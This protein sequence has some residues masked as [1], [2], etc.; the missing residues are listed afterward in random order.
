MQ[1]PIAVFIPG[2]SALRL[3]WEAGGGLDAGGSCVVCA[4]WSPHSTTSTSTSTPPNSQT[5]NP[6]P[7]SHDIP[8]ND[9]RSVDG[10][11]AF[12]KFCT[13]TDGYKGKSGYSAFEL[14]CDEV[15]GCAAVTFSTD[16]P[17][18][19][20]LKSKGTKD[21]IKPDGKWAVL[22]WQ[23]KPRKD[24]IFDPNNKCTTDAWVDQ[25]I[26]CGGNHVKCVNGQCQNTMPGRKMF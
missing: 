24:C 10:K 7:L 1:M 19:A 6:T 14:A 17:G 12:T 5:S 16:E 20:Y 3:G 23:E 22:T 13:P 2:K 4:I 9:I 21:F 18:C 8:G 15:T 26:C 25:P 11:S